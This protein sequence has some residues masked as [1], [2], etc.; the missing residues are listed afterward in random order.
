M[1]CESGEVRLSPLPLSL[2]DNQNDMPAYNWPGIL[3]A[4]LNLNGIKLVS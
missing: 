3:H 1:K 4:S 2:S